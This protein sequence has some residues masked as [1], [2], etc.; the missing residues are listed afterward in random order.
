M[1]HKT[2]EVMLTI[3][4]NIKR[5]VILLVITILLPVYGNAKIYLISVGISDYPGKVNDLRVSHNDAATMQWLYKENK[6][7]ETI[8]LMNEKATTT[9]V[10]KAMHKLY[11][12]AK[13]NDIVVLF[14]SGHGIKGGFVCYD[15]FLYYENI[16][17]EM[18][19]TQCKNKM[20]FADACF[21]GAIRSD[22]ES[23]NSFGNIK[24]ESI[25]LFLS[26]RTNERSLE[27]P[28]KTNSVFTYAL[29]HGLRG[30]ADINRDKIITAKEIYTYVKN[31]V[32]KD[33]NDKQH[34]VMWGEFS[35]TMPVIKW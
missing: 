12:K 21:S 4:Y 25:M 33:T 34:P 28:T 26:C 13:L 27:S 30:G 8:L 3:P 35:D 14:F 29:Q 7:A 20:I 9:N 16:R 10:K 11:A 1:I 6:S 5:I 32:K 18:V 22:S 17:S 2:T 31:Q 19:C 23:A 15:G 24:G